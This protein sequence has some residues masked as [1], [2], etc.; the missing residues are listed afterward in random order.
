M[1]DWLSAGMGNAALK[2]KFFKKKEFA[3][4]RRG[5]LGKRPSLLI[6]GTGQMGQ[7]SRRKIIHLYY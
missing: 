1:T 7:L 2:K 6:S 5:E 3:Q 4:G